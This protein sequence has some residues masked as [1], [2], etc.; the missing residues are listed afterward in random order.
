MIAEIII[1]PHSEILLIN[2]E[3]RKRNINM[4]DLI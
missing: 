2:S 3:L 1:K 4:T